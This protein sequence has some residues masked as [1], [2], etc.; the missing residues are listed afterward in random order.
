MGEY[1]QYTA[2][3]KHDYSS[4][5]HVDG[6]A[7]VQLVKPDCESV[8]RQILEEYYK[9]P[10]VPMLLN[11]SLNIRNK[12]MVNTIEDAIEWENKYNVKVF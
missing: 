4:V 12:P 2:I 1:M 11:T 6:T 10:G 8:L 3:A 5:S 7:R 9:L